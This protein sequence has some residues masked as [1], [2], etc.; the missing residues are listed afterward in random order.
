MKISFM[1][2]IMLISLNFFAQNI[3]E[4]GLDNNPQ[5]TTVESD[6]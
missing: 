3:E 4:C 6:F 5:L 2:L 1:I